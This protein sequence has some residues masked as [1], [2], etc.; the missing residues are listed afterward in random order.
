MT[1][2]TVPVTD[3]WTK[4]NLLTA[5]RITADDISV[6]YYVGDTAPADDTIRLR[7]GLGKSITSA[8]VTGI[9]WVKRDQ[10]D[11]TVN[12]IE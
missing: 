4:A 11:T 12:V 1:M 6:Y 2:R 8:E 10:T 3:T 7:L 9:V 5:F